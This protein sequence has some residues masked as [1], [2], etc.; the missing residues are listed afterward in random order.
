MNPSPKFFGKLLFG[1]LMLAAGAFLLPSGET[2]AYYAEQ[3]GTSCFAIQYKLYEKYTDQSKA[4]DSGKSPST[5]TDA[6][7]YSTGRVCASVDANGNITGD[8]RY[9]RGGQDGT[10]SVGENSTETSPLLSVNG[11]TVVLTTCEGVGDKACLTTQKKQEFDAS[12]GKNFK[13]LAEEV[14]KA[15]PSG[16]NID[17]KATKMGLEENENT[18]A[19]QNEAD[20]EDGAEPRNGD[21]KTAGGAKALGWVVCPILE[22]MGNAAENVY[23]DYVEPSLQIEPQLFT[24]GNESVRT[25]WGTFQNFANILFVILLLFVIFSQ[26]TGVG[27]D[28]YGIKKTLPKLILAAILINL[29]YIACLLLVDVSNILGN[30]FQ[31][32]FNGLSEALAMPSTVSIDAGS[33]VNAAIQTAGITGLTGVGVLGALVAT[34]AAVFVNPAILLSVLVSALGIVIGIFFLFILLS[35]REAAIIVLI[36]ISPLA[37]VMYALPNTKRMFDRWWKMFEG[38]LLVYP[39]CGLLVGAGGYVSRLLLVAG[40]GTGG[41]I[42][43]F[44]SMVVSIVPIFFIPVVL[45]SSFAAMGNLGARISNFGQRVS[46]TATGMARNSQAY[47]NAQ[48]L[49]L[50]RK[51]R[52]QAGV[53]INGNPISTGRLGTLMRGGKRNMARNR[54]QYL[55]NQDARGR[56]DSLMGVGYDAAVIAQTKRAEAEEMG[57]YMTLINDATRNGEDEDKLFQMFDQYMAAGNKAG[58]VAVTRI[59]GRRKDTAARFAESKVTSSGAGMG[60]GVAA[61][62]DPKMAQAVAKEMATGENSGVYRA[63]SPLAF[64]FAG[65]MNTGGTQDYNSWLSQTDASGKSNIAN[66]LEHHVTNSQELVGMKG[67]SLDELSR[68]MTDGQVDA[69]TAARISTLATQ[70][71]E[72]RDKPGATWDSTKAE[73]LAKL[74]GQYTYNRASDSLSR[75]GGRSVGGGNVERDSG[76]IVPH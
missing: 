52:I 39:I 42:S 76:L 26:L 40:A 25:A 61:G 33:D 19:L 53:D 11:S 29:S 10:S 71:I 34:G 45:K 2:Q 5:R 62:Y 69:A 72:N 51:S 18:A 68:L 30:S 1:F 73:Q 13:S 6:K 36:V 4:A 31:G 35:A 3:N 32:L 57:N 28:N 64:E 8:L 49:G 48:E 74:S 17:S 43:V 47:K 12:N 24:G 54:A 63:S 21:C 46:G 27:I 7:V 59:A 55:R 37:V 9:V 16:T 65:Q 20:K 38:L 22:W 56:E 14:Q 23:N 50:E 66:A 15:A 70:T 60:P 44:T 41:F 67:S 75:N 58:A